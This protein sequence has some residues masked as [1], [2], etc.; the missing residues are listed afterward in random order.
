M[1]VSLPLNLLGYQWWPPSEARYL[2]LP[3][4]AAPL[5]TGALALLGMVQATS[6]VPHV[7]PPYR[8]K[9]HA[10]PT[11]G[12]DVTGTRKNTVQ[13]HVSQNL[14]A[15]AY[16]TQRKGGATHPSQKQTLRLTV[17]QLQRLDQRRVVAKRGLQAIQFRQAHK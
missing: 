13:S 14:S 15:Q 16:L 10:T 8:T 7:D 2:Y 1:L 6:T 9:L 4:H 12:L 5:Y 3:S 11:N 17:I